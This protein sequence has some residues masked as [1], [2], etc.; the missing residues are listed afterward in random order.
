MKSWQIA[1]ARA[2]GFNRIITNTRKSN[3]AMVRLNKKF[4]FVVVRTSPNYYSGPSEPTVVMEL[5][6]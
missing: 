6:F 3:R 1:Y 5:R 4:T 2:H